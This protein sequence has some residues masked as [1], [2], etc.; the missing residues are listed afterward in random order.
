[1][2]EPTQTPFYQTAYVSAFTG[3][4]LL[5]EID[6]KMNQLCSQGLY[7]LKF[8]QVNEHPLPWAI[9]IFESTQMQMNG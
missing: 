5:N 4:G 9:L 7:K 6:A 1:M 8:I 2:P 3:S